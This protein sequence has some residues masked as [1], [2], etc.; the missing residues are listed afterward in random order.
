MLVVYAGG[1]AY[2]SLIPHPPQLHNELLG[3]DKLQH[4]AAYTVL[5]LLA[6]FSFKKAVA[7]KPWAAAF[8][9]ALIF[10]ISIELLQGLMGMG[11][12]ADVADVG[13]NSLGAGVA[14]LLGKLSTRSAGTP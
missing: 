1:I 2:F 8:V 10:G 9:A 4:A 5:T 3:W 7:P 12:M 14:C 6:G 11:R 13:A